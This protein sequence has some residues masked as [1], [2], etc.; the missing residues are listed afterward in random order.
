M[1]EP[2]A[3]GVLHACNAGDP[4][5]WHDMATAVVR[6]MAACG[7]I[8]GCPEITAET[9]AEIPA[10]RAARPKHTAMDSSRLAGVLGPPRPWPEALAEY[11]RSRCD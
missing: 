8:A 4:V 11:V 5:R 1:L 6:E 10:F 2:A 3:C 9:M 7:A